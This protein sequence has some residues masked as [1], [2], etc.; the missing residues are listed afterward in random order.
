MSARDTRRPRVRSHSSSPASDEPRS[1][2]TARRRPRGDRA[3][4]SNSPCRTATAPSSTRRS[5]ATDLV[6]GA[7]EKVP[8]IRWLARRILLALRRAPARAHDRRTRTRRDRLDLP[9]RHGRAEPTCGARGSCACPTIATITDLT[10]LFF[11]A[12]K[13]IDMHLVMYDEVAAGRRAHRRAGLRTG[14]APADLRR[15]P[16]A[17]HAGGLRRAL[18]LPRGRAHGR[19][20]RR[21]LGCRR[22]RGRRRASSPTTPRSPRSS[23]SQGATTSCANDSTRPSPAMTDHGVRLHGADARVLAAADVLVH[24]TGGVTCL[25]APRD[26]LAG[27][28]LRPADR[29]RATEHAGDGRPRSAAPRARSRRTERTRRRELW[30]GR[31]RPAVKGAPARRRQSSSTRRGASHPR[32]AGGCAAGRWPRRPRSVLAAG[33]LDDEHDEVAA[34]AQ[35]TLGC[36]R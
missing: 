1:T 8:P 19:R 21:R 2:S 16:A 32:R 13:G 27:R 30:R 20:L 10:G 33:R 31:R 26:R 24:S 5:G 4:C 6:Y 9:G 7:V 22:H 29:A 25:E 34:L 35:D 28:L 36:N 3:A 14:R 15:L 18:G 12:Q 23:A 17:P 11:W